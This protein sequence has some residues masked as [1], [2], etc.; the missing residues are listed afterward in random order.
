MGSLDRLDEAL[1]FLLLLLAD[2]GGLR[3][4]F[5]LQFCSFLRLNQSLFIVFGRL[6]SSAS[7]HPIVV[8]DLSV[9]ATNIS[10]VIRKTNMF[11]QNNNCEG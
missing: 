2:K 8:A 11:L 5:L 6:I 9:L 4:L 3:Y 1:V 10:C 7:A